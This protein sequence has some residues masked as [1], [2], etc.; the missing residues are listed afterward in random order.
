M[1]NKTFYTEPGFSVDTQELAKLVALSREFGT[2]TDID[3]ANVIADNVSDSRF[4][5]DR[6]W[7]YMIRLAAVYNVGYILGKR[8]ERKRRTRA[9]ENT[10]TQNSVKAIA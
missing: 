9:K 1:E 2:L 4:S 10:H 5:S 6:L 7:N 8:A 3:I